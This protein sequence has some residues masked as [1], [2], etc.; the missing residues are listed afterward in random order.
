[1]SHEIVRKI[2]ITGH[3]VFVTSKCNNDTAPIREWHCIYYDEFFS[4]GIEKVQLEIFKSFESYNFQSDIKN[5]W[6][7][8]LTKLE[9]NP[10]YAKFNW[11]NKYNG[12]KEQDQMIEAA[13]NSP[14]FEK[15]LKKALTNN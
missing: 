13:R 15:I 4:Q 1:M 2:R 8:A 6:T 3:Q 7:K 10:E 12:N 5:K 14:E 11:R 9:Q